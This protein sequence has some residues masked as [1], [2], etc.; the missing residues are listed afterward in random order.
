MG[1]R[2]GEV[3]GVVWE[4]GAQCRCGGGRRCRGIVEGQHRGMQ[5]TRA[6]VEGRHGG[7]R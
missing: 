1:A 2:G 7:G 3:E 6:Q 4:V 5:P